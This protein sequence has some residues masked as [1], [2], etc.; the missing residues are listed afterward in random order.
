MIDRNKSSL[1]STSRRRLSLRS[2]SKYQIVRGLYVFGAGLCAISAVLFLVSIPLALPRS[3]PV[4]IFL[5]NGIAAGIPGL[6]LVAV[7]LFFANLPRRLQ[8]KTHL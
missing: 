4:S 2:A 3:H 6:L 5:Q 1:A 8:G 7:G